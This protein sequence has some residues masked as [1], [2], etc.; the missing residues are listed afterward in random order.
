[1]IS[2]K[3]TINH[4]YEVDIDHIVPYHVVKKELE[5]LT[6]FTYKEPEEVIDTLLTSFSLQFQYKPRI[7]LIHFNI[8]EHEKDSEKEEP[9]RAIIGIKPT[10]AYDLLSMMLEK[11]YKD[12]EMSSGFVLD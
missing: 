2:N 7:N 5:K 1:M 3:L 12:I 11:D 4:L 6:G 10:R 8:S 9:N